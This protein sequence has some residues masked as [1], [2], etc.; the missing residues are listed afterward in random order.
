MILL[1]YIMINVIILD[2]YLIQYCILLIVY[3]YKFS[4]T[5]LR[6]IFLHERIVVN[7]L[8]NAHLYVVDV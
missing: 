4:M 2:I 6:L 8:S 1:L 5:I 7:T 3:K